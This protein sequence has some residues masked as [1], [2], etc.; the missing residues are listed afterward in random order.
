MVDPEGVGG[1][2]VTMIKTH[3]QSSQRIKTG[4]GGERKRNL[5]WAGKS[6]QRK[7]LTMGV[8]EDVSTNPQGPRESQ[9][10]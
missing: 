3:L 1:T 2:E 9:A 5:V 8:C 10:C 4:D 7:S 6:A